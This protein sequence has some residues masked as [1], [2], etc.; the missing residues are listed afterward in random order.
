MGSRTF[1]QAQRLKDLSEETQ[2]G[3]GHFSRH[4]S[5]KDLSDET[6]CMDQGHFSRLALALLGLLINGHS[7]FR[8]ISANSTESKVSLWDTV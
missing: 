4:S 5:F 1:Q 3:Q 2:W 8:Y 6:Q 7:S